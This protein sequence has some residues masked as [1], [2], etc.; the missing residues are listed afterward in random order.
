MGIKQLIPLVD[1]NNAWM[2]YYIETE[3]SL[4]NYLYLLWFEFHSIVWLNSNKLCITIFFSTLEKLDYLWFFLLANMAPNIKIWT[5][6]HSLVAA[7]LQVSTLSCSQFKCWRTRNGIG[8]QSRVDNL[9]SLILP[10]W[11]NDSLP[12]A[13]FLVHFFS[14]LA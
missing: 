12:E 7:Y 10:L 2:L 9:F 8:K 14:F 3:H 4:L 1:V 13:W 6:N 5:S 11:E